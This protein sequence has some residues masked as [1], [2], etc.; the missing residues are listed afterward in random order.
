ML[1]WAIL[2]A[3]PTILPLAMVFRPDLP[4]TVAEALLVLGVVSLFLAICAAEAVGSGK[5]GR[6]RTE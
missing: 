5:A 1:N 6:G 2:L 3:G 4:N